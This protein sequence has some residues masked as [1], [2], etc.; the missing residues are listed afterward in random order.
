VRQTPTPPPPPPVTKTVRFTE[1]TKKVPPAPT[2]VILAKEEQEQEHKYE[3]KEEQKQY[4]YE[5]EDR[6]AYRIPPLYY[7]LG[8][9]NVYV[10]L[11]TTGVHTEV[12]SIYDSV[13]V[14]AEALALLED[15]TYTDILNKYKRWKSDH[16][17]R[18]QILEHEPSHIHT[19]TIIKLN[20]EIRHIPRPIATQLYQWWQG[21][22]DSSSSTIIDRH[23]FVV[24]LPRIDDT[25]PLFHIEPHRLNH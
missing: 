23:V 1:P 4:Y 15:T 18:M 7:S 17:S 13:N 9:R 25:V 11:R 16:I 20:N 8:A 22:H 10:L 14:A 5:H 3:E 21:L 12:V 24:L 6:V 2:P 19:H